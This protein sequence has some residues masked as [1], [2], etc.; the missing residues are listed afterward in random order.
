MANI[1]SLRFRALRELF[2]GG[3]LKIYGHKRTLYMRM[4]IIKELPVFGCPLS[5]T[6]LGWPELDLDS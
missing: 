3:K 6:V 5:K 4:E 1:I 2:K